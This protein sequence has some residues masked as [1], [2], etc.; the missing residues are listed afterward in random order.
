M[1]GSLG[2]NQRFEDAVKT[3][4]GED[5]Y[6]D[7]RKM[8]GYHLGVRTFDREVKRA[9]KGGED[10]EYF[11]HF[12]MCS[13]EDDI[14]AGLDSNCWR[15]TGYVLHSSFKFNLQSTDTWVRTVWI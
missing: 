10:E 15:L 7:L 11:V 12:P 8:K 1:A 6:A 2:L 5:Q 13:L 3:L 9:F 4:V 14:E